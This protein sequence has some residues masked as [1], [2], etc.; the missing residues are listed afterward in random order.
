MFTHLHLH[1]H[2][3]L[4]DGL[5]NPKKLI[6]RVK[7][8]GMD[9][10]AVTDHGNMYGAIEFY[11]EAKAQGIKPI[12]GCEL[13]TTADMSIKEKIKEHPIWHLIAL[14][15]NETGYKN[16]CKI[17]T[18]ANI[19]GFYYKP[20]IDFSLLEMYHEGLIILSGCLG[21]ELSQ[22]IL[23]GGDPDEVIT[24]YKGLLGDRYYIELQ[25][26]ENNEDQH[27]VTPELIRLAKK[28]G[29]PTVATSDSHYL[30]EEDAHTHDVLL[31]INTQ[32]SIDDKQRMSMIDDDFSVQPGDVM[33]EKFADIPQAVT[34]TQIISDRCNVEIELGETRLPPFDTENN[35]THDEGLE[36]LSRSGL[37]NLVGDNKEYSDRLDYELDIIRKTGFASYMLIIHDIVKWAKEQ[38]IRVGPGRGSAAGSL[39]SYSL[40][41]TGV[42]PIHYGLLFERFMNPDRI[43]MPDI[44]LDFEDKRRDE[45]IQYAK[46]KYGHDFVAQIITFGSMFARTSIRD[47]ARAM[48]YDLAIADKVAKV[49]PMTMSITEALEKVPEVRAMYKEQHELMDVAKDLEGVVRNAGTHA[50][51]VVIGDRPLTEYMPLQ[52]SSKS[53]DTVTTQ[54]DMG[55]VEDLGLLKMDFLGLRNLTVIN[56]TIKLIKEHYGTDV[57]I[58]NIPLDDDMT[59]MLFQEAKTTSVFQMESGGMKRYLKE[60]KPTRFDD[61]T[62][63]I[64]LYRPGPMDL[65]PSYIDRSHG[66]EDITYLHPNLEPILKDT[67]GIMIYQEQLMS[68]VRALAG[69]TLAEADILRKAVGKKIPTLLYEQESKFK[70]GCRKNGIDRLTTDRFWELIEPFSR[71]GFNKSHAVS[72]AMIAYQTA[73]LKANYP[74]QF[75]LSEMNSSDSIERITE[76]LSEL[77]DMGIKV[78]P[79]DINESVYGFSGSGN[80][81]RFS[82]NSV[83]GAGSKTVEKLV[84]GQPY[85]TFQDFVTKV[86]GI[87]K[88]T[89]DVLARAG[90]FDDLVDNRY[91]V[92]EAANQITT[93][94]KADEGVIRPPLLLPEIPKPTAGQKLSWE[95]ELL[96]FYL[97][98]NPADRYESTFKKHGAIRIVDI[99]DAES[100]FIKVGGVISD[101]K[102]VMTRSGKTIYFATLLDSSGSIEVPVFSNMY[103]KFKNHLKENNV[104]IMT[105]KIDRNR[106]KNPFMCFGVNSVGTVG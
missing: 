90:A 34:N 103:A 3:S 25:R 42:D 10:V 88:K 98:S 4:L 78:T 58:D 2:Y 24:R 86:N 16:L 32:K 28:H 1:T 84:E 106:D 18:Q 89:L 6:K 59:F 65:I 94:M 22:S 80:T 33:M 63:M 99:L 73:Y 70:D 51:G 19:D 44:D 61:I 26:H 75:M 93:Y 83:K 97:S 30:C 91:A 68:S 102:K 96:G 8:L 104:V 39:I 12:L 38:G 79:P 5:S 74:L 105:G 43:S 20:R 47:A 27:K 13:Y 36:I 29:V 52:R 76:L 55:A 67:H 9:S 46:E 57:D 101:F 71:Y 40:G 81:I 21:G 37:Y 77:R 92:I 49:L 35:I 72:Y 95:K 64:S 69:F 48:N 62:V 14:A 100:T 54:Y 41:I 11:K 45:V 53:E 60:L 50:C 23:N 66:E 7:D 87:N 31:A 56:D 82:L 85:G 17:I 15:M